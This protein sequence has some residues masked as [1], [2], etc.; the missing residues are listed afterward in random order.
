MYKFD[1]LSRDLRCLGDLRFL[2]VYVSRSLF[3]RGFSFSRG[4]SFSRSSFSRGLLFW[5][6][7]LRSSFSRHPSL[8][9]ERWSRIGR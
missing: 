4:S 9:L 3:S 1:S 7:S 5:G 8:T 2:G 6:L